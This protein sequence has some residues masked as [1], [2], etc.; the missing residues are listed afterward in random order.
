LCGEAFEEAVGLPDAL[1]PLEQ[2]QA[3]GQS[4]KDTSH[5]NPL[6]RQ[7]SNHRW[8]GALSSILLTGVYHLSLLQE[9]GHDA[10]S[11]MEWREQETEERPP[12]E[13]WSC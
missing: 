1:L 7:K 8:R 5:E 3:I 2:Q 9:M 12:S 11:P 13:L 4:D 6:A 10:E